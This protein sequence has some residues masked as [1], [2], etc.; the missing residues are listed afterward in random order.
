MTNNS[1]VITAILTEWELVKNKLDQLF[2]ER[3]S[4]GTKE[5]MEKGLSLFIRLLYLTNEVSGDPNQHIPFGQ[6]EYKPFNAEERLMFI[7]ARPTLYH[8]YRQ[9]AE[10]MVEQEKLYAKKTVKKSSRPQA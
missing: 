10:L 3:N 2:H 8:S 6:L 5:M 9:L 1:E 4:I 7:Q